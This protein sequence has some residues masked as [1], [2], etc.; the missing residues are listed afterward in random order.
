MTDDK[1]TAPE[2]RTPKADFLYGVR[3]IARYMD[4]REPQARHLCER[5]DI[6]TSAR[7]ARRSTPVLLSVK[8]G[9]LPVKRR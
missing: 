5:G 7:G 4:L 8:P 2:E 3:A 9:R 1:T 6:P